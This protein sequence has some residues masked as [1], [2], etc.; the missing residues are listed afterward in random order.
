MI[1]TCTLSAQHIFEYEREIKIKENYNYQEIEF[2]NT[3]DKIKLSGTLISP[4][5]EFNKIVLII[6]DTGKDPRYA[7][8]VLAEEL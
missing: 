4:K 8:F 5:T 3:L 6:P 2:H 1:F 7:H